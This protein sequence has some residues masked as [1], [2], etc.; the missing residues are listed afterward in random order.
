MS[1]FNL[2][3]PFGRSSVSVRFL[4]YVDERDDLDLAFLVDSPFAAPGAGSKMFFWSRIDREQDRFMVLPSTGSDWAFYEDYLV[5]AQGFLDDTGS[6]PVKRKLNAEMLALDELVEFRSVARSFKAGKYVLHWDPEVISDQKVQAIAEIRQTALSRAIDLTGVAANDLVID[7]YLYPD[8]ETKLTLTGIRAGAHVVGHRSQLHATIRYAASDSCHEEIHILARRLL[9]VTS[10]TAAYEGLSFSFEP[11]IS[12]QP[13]AFH[14]A[15][16]IDAG[17]V[18]SIAS[19][20]DASEFATLGKQEAYAA[21]GLL[22]TWLREKKGLA[23]LRPWYSSSRSD[24]PALASLLGVTSQQVEREYGTWLGKRT[25]SFAGDVAFVN[26]QREAQRHHD[27]GDFA[28]VAGALRKAVQY[29]PQDWQTRFN[30]AA[31]MIRLREY[32]AT[33]KE[34]RVILQSD[35]SA[36]HTLKIF[37]HLQLGRLFDLTGRREEARSE[38]QKMLELPDVHDSHIAAREGLDSPFTKDRLQ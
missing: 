15:L 9:G 33:E 30:L 22:M 19:L 21:T 5:V 24:L 20:L 1:R 31:A 10:S 6:W 25:Q 34:L 18:P 28:G 32:E 29:R 7:L 36:D 38:Y 16:M 3:S 11:L 35:L 27:N 2:E 23:G 26:A 13:L 12:G 37:S 14:V 8:A 4:D 17:T